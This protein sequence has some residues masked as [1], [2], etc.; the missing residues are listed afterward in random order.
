MKP[1]EAR[2]VTMDEFRV[3]LTDIHGGIASENVC[4]RS[5]N[6]YGV[7]DRANH[8]CIACLEAQD[9]CF[10]VLNRFQPWLKRILTGERRI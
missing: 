10:A 8:G 3:D 2:V 6:A 9:E 1:R 4:G 7:N 5:E